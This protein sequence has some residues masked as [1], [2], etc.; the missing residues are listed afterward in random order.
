IPGE[1]SQTTE[2]EAV[3]EAAAT[4]AAGLEPDASKRSAQ[5]HA[6]AV[7]SSFKRYGINRWGAAFIRA[8]D[9]GHLVFEAPNSPPVDLFMLSEE[10]RQRGIHTPYVVRFPTMIEN[11]MSL[12]KEAFAKACADNSY[13][14][15]HIGVF[16]LKVNQRRAVVDT[17]V[18]ARE[19]LDYG[20]E[21]GSKP[22]LLLAM[23]QPPL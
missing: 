5:A 12:L 6:L 14:G 4:A 15:R 11:Q 21:A 9:E 3:K 10:L 20:L 18:K 2:A 22:E 8:T 16:P 7:E 19:R 23:A 1:M 17:V 13:R